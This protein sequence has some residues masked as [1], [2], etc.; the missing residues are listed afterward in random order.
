M[1][2]PASEE[3]TETETTDEATETTDTAAEETGAEGEATED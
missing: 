2:D 1:G 3:V